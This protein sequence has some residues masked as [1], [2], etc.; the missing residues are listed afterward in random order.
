LLPNLEA[1]QLPGDQI[2]KLLAK[3]GKLKGPPRHGPKEE[4]LRGPIPLSWLTPAT[5]LS[6][7]ALALALAL[8]FQ[9]GRKNCREV[10]LSSP[11][12]ERF[13]VNRKALYRGLDSLEAAGLVSVAKRKGKNPTVTILDPATKETKR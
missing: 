7:K 10:T 2:A 5:R 9:S 8:W 1:L 13:H 4:F 6:G 11:I 3:N 12:L